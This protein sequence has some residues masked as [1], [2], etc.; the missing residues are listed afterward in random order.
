MTADGHIITIDNL[1]KR[2][3]CLV[4]RLELYYTKSESNDHIVLHSIFAQDIWE[5]I[6]NK[7][8]INWVQLNYFK[9]FLEAW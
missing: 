5:E 1:N 8:N 7:L 4:N 3:F 9:D 2:G 6:L